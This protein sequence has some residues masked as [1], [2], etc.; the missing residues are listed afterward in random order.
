MTGAWDV[1]ADALG[2]SGPNGNDHGSSNWSAWGHPEIRT[3]LDNTVDPANIYEAAEAWREQGRNTMQVLT[4]FT[5]D[6]TRIVTD[7]WRGA[8]AEAA[9]ATFG[10]IDQ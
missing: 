3:M 2:F 1:V 8:A 7:G 9:L 6:L 4:G 5:R 10:P